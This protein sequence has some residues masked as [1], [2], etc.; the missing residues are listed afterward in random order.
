MKTRKELYE[1][2]M[3]LKRRMIHIVDEKGMNHPV[4]IQTSQKLDRLITEYMK[5]T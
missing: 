3:S 5:L 2:I 1:E 4:T